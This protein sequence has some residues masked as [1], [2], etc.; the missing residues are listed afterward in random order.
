M[1]ASKVK[2]ETANFV[3]E[4]EERSESLPEVKK[5]EKDATQ[6]SGTLTRQGQTNSSQLAQNNN[7]TGK[8]GRNNPLASV[9]P[10]CLPASLE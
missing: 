3:E 7:A 2:Q 4:I 1:A 8:L 9:A 10:V 5:E 6:T